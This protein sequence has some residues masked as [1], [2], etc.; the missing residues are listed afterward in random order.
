MPFAKS[1]LLRG[2]GICEDSA[3][4][5]EKSNSNALNR[6]MDSCQR[7]AL[8]CARRRQILIDAASRKH[9]LHLHFQGPWPRLFVKSLFWR[10]IFCAAGERS[11]HKETARP[12]T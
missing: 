4:A 12:S 9:R 2:A 10:L 7:R 11:R 3:G 1:G 6:R 5:V 8:T